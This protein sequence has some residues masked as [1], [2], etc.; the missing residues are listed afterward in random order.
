MQTL[1][2]EALAAAKRAGTFAKIPEI[3]R[4]D[5]VDLA[6]AKDQID[7]TGSFIQEF[8]TADEISITSKDSVDLV[9][10]I[11]DKSLSAVQVTEAFCKR[12][13]IAHQIVLIHLLFP[14]W[15]GS[16]ISGDMSYL[17]V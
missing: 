9:N 10:E 5:P 4:L 8:L 13:A 15:R 11:R 6:R 16:N 12:A 14:S 1:S 2:W 17:S 7:L 3:W